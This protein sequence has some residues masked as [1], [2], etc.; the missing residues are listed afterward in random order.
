MPALQNN[1][2]GKGEGKGK[3][4][5]KSANREG[6]WPSREGRGEAAQRESGAQKKSG[7]AFGS[8]AFFETETDF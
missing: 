8:A 3:S 4:K 2:K 5:S 7:G 6:D 1:G